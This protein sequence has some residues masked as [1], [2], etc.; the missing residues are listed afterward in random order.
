M[1]GR[2]RCF[3]GPRSLSSGN[4][5]WL[6]NSCS[7]SA[8]NQSPLGVPLV[9]HVVGLA[10]PVVGQGPTPLHTDCRY[11]S[12]PS[13]VGHLPIVERQSSTSARLWFTIFR[14]RGCSVPAF[15]LWKENLPQVSFRLFMTHWR[16][17][18]RYIQSP[19]IALSLSSLLQ[20]VLPCIY[21]C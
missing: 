7:M 9:I 20:A 17:S 4:H 10:L 3:P 8:G 6:P 1:Y 5:N 18:P 16:P 14:G 15:P 21:K 2:V 13:A 12:S 11:I 19:I